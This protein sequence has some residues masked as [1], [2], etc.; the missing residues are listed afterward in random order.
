[1]RLRVIL[2]KRLIQWFPRR[3]A[4]YKGLVKYCCVYPCWALC[5]SGLYTQQAT[6]PFRKHNGELPPQKW[7][8][9]HFIQL[10][11]GEKIGTSL[12]FHLF[13]IF[14]VFLLDWRSNENHSCFLFFLFIILIKVEEHWLKKIMFLL[15]II[16]FDNQNCRISQG[17]HLKT[18]LCYCH[19]YFK[20]VSGKTRNQ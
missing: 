7:Q 3:P 18:F 14:W 13:F 19:V 5:R 6:K 8:F 15:E 10:M 20:V 9:D 4:S 16:N 11:K 1:M 12:N 2:T 17:F